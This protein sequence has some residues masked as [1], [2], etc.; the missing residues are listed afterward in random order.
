MPVE[1]TGA[2]ELRKALKEYAP[3]L[4]KESQ[5]EISGILRPVAIRARGFMPSNEQVPSGW[6]ER[7]NAG[8]RW[9]NRFYDQAAARKGITFSA[10]PSKFNRKG[11]KSLAAIYNKSAAGAIYETAGR[12][13]GVTG[14]FTPKLGGQLKGYNQKLTGRGIFRAW[15]EDQGKTNAAVIRAIE[16][17]NEKVAN[18]AKMGGGKLFRVTKAE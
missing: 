8:G 14:N 2:L 9:A 18:L 1:V 13:S 15:S 11:F 7:P 4:A 12:L 3:F 16:R 10:A 6:L 17:A 5:K